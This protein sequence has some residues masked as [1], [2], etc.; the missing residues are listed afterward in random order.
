M[1]NDSSFSGVLGE[2]ATLRN[3]RGK[4]VVKNRPKRQPSRATPDSKQEAAKAR[5]LEATQYGRQ[6]ISMA[7]S[8]ELYAKRVTAKKRSAYAVAMSDYLVEPKVHSIDTVDYHG[9]IGD[10]ITVKATD[11]FMVTKVKIVIKDAAGELI[12]EGNAGPD[13]LKINLW[14]YKATAAS[15]KLTGTKIQAVA[16]DRPGNVGVAEV[17]L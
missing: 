15:P 14:A 6:Q 1:K 11:D 13:E 8:K 2:S 4:L 16:Y 17:V 7:E 12:E 3:V 10:T 9:V 5:F